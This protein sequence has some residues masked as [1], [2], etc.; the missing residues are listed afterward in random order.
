MVRGVG[1]YRVETVSRVK[2]CEKVVFYYRG[3]IASLPLLFEDSNGKLRVLVTRE[4][5]QTKIL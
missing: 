4:S 3:N 2:Y 1:G 5:T